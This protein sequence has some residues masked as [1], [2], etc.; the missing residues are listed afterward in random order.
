MADRHL[1]V[2]KRSSGP[3]NVIREP[4]DNASGR[5]KV[6]RRTDG[7]FVAHDTEAWPTSGKVFRDEDA[8]RS[9][10]GLSPRH[11]VHGPKSAGEMSRHDRALMAA[12][13]ELGAMPLESRMRDVCAG[14]GSHA[15]SDEIA[16]LKLI[17]A[18]DTTL[19]PHCFLIAPAP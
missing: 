15:V 14:C 3:G 1:S 12:R 18:S 13:K 4:E 5:F 6:L 19:C 16:R 11:Q 9:A 2:G 7:Q 10:I 8:A 17:E